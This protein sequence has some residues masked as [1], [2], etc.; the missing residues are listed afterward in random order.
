MRLRQICFV[1]KDL[2]NALKRFS[3]IIDSEVCFRDE[4]VR[5]FGL[6]NGLLAIDGNFIEVVSPFKQDTTAERFMSK[7]NGDTGYMLIFEC[8]NADLYR[9]KA[10]KF[11]IRS[12]W[13]TDLEN[14]VKATHYHPKDI[15]GLIISVD[16]MNKKDWQDKNSYWQWAGDDWQLKTNNQCSISSISMSCKNP[17]KLANQ[18]GSFLDLSVNESG[19]IYIIE[20]A[21]FKIFFMYDDIKRL[22]YLSQL[23]LKINNSELKDKI[24]QKYKENEI[25]IC[26]TKIELI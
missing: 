1:A 20:G 2:E 10:D 18:W 7:M 17:S 14:G 16:S 23:T 21:D 13:K 26:G 8:E 22:D 3:F 5:H 12:I 11:N 9:Q 6:E 15:G 19:D 4:G 24:F 25:E